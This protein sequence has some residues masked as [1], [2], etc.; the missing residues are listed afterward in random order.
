[1]IHEEY[2]P[3]ADE[4]DGGWRVADPRTLGVD[5]DQLQKAL[6]AHDTDDIFTRRYGG[7]LVIVYKG[8]I[9]GERY[10]TG[11]MG[12]PQPWTPHTCNDIKSSTKSV[13]GTAVGVFLEEYRDRIT[14][15][16]RLVGTCRE[17]SLI[18]QIWDQ[19][20][21]DDRKTKITIKHMLSMTSGHASTEPWLAPSS[22]QVY[23]KYSSAFQM[24][25]YCFGWWYFEG[26]PAHRILLFDPG[27]R[28]NYSNF[29]LELLALAMRNISGEEV[30]PYLYDRVLGQIGLPLGLRD[31]QYT[32]MPYTDDH[33]WNFSDEPGWGR[34]GSHGCN[35]YGA[36]RSH[37]PYGYNSL[38]GSTLRC[39]ARDFARIGYLWL[40]NG[41]W[42]QQQLVPQAWMTQATQRVI[43]E[44]GDSL[45]NYGYTF[46]IQ[47]D[48][49]HVPHD[50]F[51]ARGHNLNI[52][53][54]V[55]SVDLVVVRQGNAQHTRKAQSLFTEMLLQNI[56]AVL[57][58]PS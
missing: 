12:G 36:D 5:V 14:I 21:T 53:Y 30:G 28:F 4:C 2:F 54:V 34:G 40:K 43:Q 3:P 23:P 46:W 57:P 44:N 26:V 25:E 10:V 41:R 47:D 55:P 50:T 15:D 9:I 38:V 33:E 22:R 29:G 8:H 48:W 39:T 31:N 1:M 42:G 20:L 17:D 24:Y 19:P 18:P 27:T 37:S 51:M 11:T 45:A 52:C 32:E 7:A 58:T 56:V 35:A 16:T 13:F 49:D 6:N